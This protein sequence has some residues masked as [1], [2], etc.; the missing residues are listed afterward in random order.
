MKTPSTQLIIF[1]FLAISLILLLAWVALFPGAITL[2]S[3]QAQGTLL[4]PYPGP[5]PYPDPYPD[6]FL[7]IIFKILAP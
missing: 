5:Y 7:P 3:A 2:S 6:V 4:N 1:T